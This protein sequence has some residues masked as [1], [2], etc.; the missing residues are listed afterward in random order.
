MRIRWSPIIQALAL[1]L[2]ALPLA[3]HPGHEEPRPRSEPTRREPAPQRER[4]DAPARV[5][6]GGGGGGGGDVGV[7]SGRRQSALRAPHGGMLVR[8]SRGGYAELLAD[9]A[10]NISLWWLDAGG[11]VRPASVALAT[12]TGATGARPVV[13]KPMGDRATAVLPKDSSTIVVQATV[14]GRLTTVRAVLVR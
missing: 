3:A 8:T 1:S 5:Q 4:N 9:K 7:G 6:G 2:V 12:V 11:R 10:G 14:D 13:L